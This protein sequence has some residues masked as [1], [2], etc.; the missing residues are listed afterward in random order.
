MITDILS[1][2]FILPG[3][4]MV[5]SA[6]VGAVRFR[7]TMA[8]VHAITKPQTTG[9]VLLAIGTIIRV[10]GAEDFSV[11]ERSDI[12]KLV[13]LTIFALMT[14]PVTA[15]R[16]GRVSRLE[17]LYGDKDELTVNQRPARNQ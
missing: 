3:A 11:Y 6:A 1:L 2:V 15:Q 10:T 4:F 9:L 14:N 7:S 16:I 12:G 5:F 13:L 8:R 17:G